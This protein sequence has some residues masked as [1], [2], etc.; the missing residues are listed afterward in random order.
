MQQIS[1]VFQQ[2]KKFENRLRFNTATD[3]L[4][5]DFLR[6]IVST[7]MRPSNTDKRTGAII[8]QVN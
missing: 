1:Y 4:M 5:G 7:A 2:C 6:H 8:L 3:S